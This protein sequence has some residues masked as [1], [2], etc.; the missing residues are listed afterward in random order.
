MVTDGLSYHPGSGM[1]GHYA[2]LRGTSAE[3]KPPSLSEILNFGFRPCKNSSPPPQQL[4][5]AVLPEAIS[6]AQLASEGLPNVAVLPRRHLVP[7][8]L[9]Y[10]LYMS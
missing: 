2:I 9:K 5:P 8:A 7:G 1:S 10:I 3:I 6:V 4:P